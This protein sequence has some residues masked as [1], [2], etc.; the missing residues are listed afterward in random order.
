ME[1]D[2][3]IVFMGTPDFA[4]PTLRALT[5]HYRVV[6]VVTKPDKPKGR[7]NKL[8]PPPVKEFAQTCGRIRPAA[9]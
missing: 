3:K 6:C 7:G 4:I 9:Q 5:E 1:K 8:T 2:L